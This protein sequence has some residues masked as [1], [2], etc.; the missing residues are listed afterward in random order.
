MY[1]IHPHMSSLLSN[2]LSLSLYYVP[3]TVLG[4]GGNTERKTDMGTRTR[5]SGL[6]GLPK[7]S[8]RIRL[9]K[10]MTFLEQPS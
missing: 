1:G 4:A 7:D 8:T 10:S 3:G 2:Q 6:K 5:A 9:L